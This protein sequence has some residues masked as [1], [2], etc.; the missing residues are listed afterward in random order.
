MAKTNTL[1]LIIQNSLSWN[2]NFYLYKKN[3]CYQIR[4]KGSTIYDI[5][6]EFLCFLCKYNWF[7]ETQF[8]NNEPKLWL[9]AYNNGTASFISRNISANAQRLN[10]DM[11]IAFKITFALLIKLLIL[12]CL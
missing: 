7:Y 11:E 3:S 9:S 6:G 1:P 10:R 2:Y 8:W 4:K 5:I 12:Y